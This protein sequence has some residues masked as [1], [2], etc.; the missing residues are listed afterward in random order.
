MRLPYRAM[1]RERRRLPADRLVGEPNL[2]VGKQPG[3]VVSFVG[4][5]PV[6]FLVRVRGRCHLVSPSASAANEYADDPWGRVIWPDA[7]VDEPVAGDRC[8]DLVWEVRR[9]RESAR[10]L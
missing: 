8:S 2:F 9:T 6:H 1:Q 5:Y 4:R 7:C 3:G 10:T